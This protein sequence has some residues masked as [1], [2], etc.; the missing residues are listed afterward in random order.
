MALNGTITKSITG[1]KY[2]IEWSA[3]QSISNNTS[4]ITCVH[5][6]KNDAS[7]SL[8]IYSRSNTCTVGG[9]Q[10]SYTSPNINTS[11]GSTITL[12]TTKH[13][14]SH[15]SDG[16]KSVTISGTFNIQATLSGSYVSSLTASATV[17]LDTI[18]RSSSLL[19]SAESLNVGE[20]ITASI[21]RASSNFTHT[22]EFYINDTYYKKYTDVGT[23]QSFVIPTSW[24]NAMPSSNECT[25]Y[26]RIT[27]YNGSTQIGSQVKKSFKIKVASSIKPKLGTIS[28]DP[29]NITTVNGTSSKILVQG[30]NKITVS[31]SGC[32][33]GTGSAIKSYT[34][35]A[36]Y[37]STA[38][39]TKTVTSTSTN[40]SASFGPFIQTG[41]I[42][43]RVTVT[44][45]RSR[46][47]NNSGSEPTQTCY[48]YNSPS[49]SSFTAY[50]CNSNGTADENGT[51]I[52]YSL[53]IRNSSVNSTNISTVKIYYKK[54][55]A[56]SYAAA[57]NALTNSTS[58]STTA[59]IANSSGAPITFDANSTYSVY[60][61]IIDN[62]GGSTNSST[63]TVFGA[64]RIFNIRENGTGIAFGKMAE[65]DNLLESKWPI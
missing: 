21:T 47:A 20:K 59:I 30:K 16:K 43:F 63:V 48:A 51:Y 15:D 1:R 33:A 65:S 34:F 36:M 12:G 24:Y 52:K 19:M 14:V 10:K 39:E 8:S 28:V 58:T 2:I 61:T 7:Y 45:K 22:V 27:T 38:L 55:T 18:P 57:A 37:G 35:V 41:S 53:N 46:S 6:L 56:S 29:A 5:K 60:A 23:S 3:T 62:Y 54:S 49:F 26:C 32:E 64:S 13:T 9:E 11:G 4:T 31:V 40:A 17:T 50:R 42:K 44:D 25:A